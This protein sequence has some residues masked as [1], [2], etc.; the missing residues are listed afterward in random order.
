MRWL[1]LLMTLV[2]VYLAVEAVRWKLS[3]Q[4]IP[5]RE[6]SRLW[7]GGLNHMNLT[8]RNALRQRYLSTSLGLGNLTWLLVATALVM[9]VLTLREFLTTQR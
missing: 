4:N 5:F 7:R 1:L 2:V 3:A 8:E 9:I 6:I